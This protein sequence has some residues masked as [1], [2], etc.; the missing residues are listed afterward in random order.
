MIVKV[1]S[2]GQVIIPKSIRKRM[3]IKKG[4]LVEFKE[5]GENHLEMYVIRDPVDELEGILAGEGL[6]RILEKEHREEIKRDEIYSR[7]MGGTSMARKRK[8]VSQSKG[9]AR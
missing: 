6:T 3:Q 2:K 9:T 1:S 5:I 7:R 8:R 4:S